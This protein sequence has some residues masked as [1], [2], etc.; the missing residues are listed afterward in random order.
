[1]EDILY[2]GTDRGVYVS[3]DRGDSWSALQGGLPNV[4]VHDLVVHPRERELVAGTHGRSI[5]IVDVLP[6][7]DLQEAGSD[8]AL[9]VFYV[10]EVK[11]GRG[12]RGERSRWFF[13]PDDA[14]KSTIK[15]WASSAG[16]A[17]VEIIDSNDAVVRRL[18]NEA[19]QG[20]NSFDW[21]LLVD[22]EL[23]LA[24]EAAAQAAAST[25]D[26]DEEKAFSLADTPYAESVRLGHTLYAVPGDYT[27]RV[28]VGENSD[29]VEL[30]IKPP[31]DFEPRF[32]E[33]YKLRGKK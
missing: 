6:L 21:D 28:S 22:E 29:S 24:A 17:S 8:T 25:A 7:Q 23:A 19:V 1:M 27:I 18:S 13:R 9:K 33:P 15:Y 14:P 12:W 26:T 31:K 20:M 11:A 2:V 4:P 5:W 32:E 16:T 10:D 30:K 3:T